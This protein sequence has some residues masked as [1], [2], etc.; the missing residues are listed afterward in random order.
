MANFCRKEHALI[1]DEIVS[2]DGAAELGPALCAPI[3]DIAGGL[4]IERLEALGLA[5]GG[6]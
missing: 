6:V 5:H 2:A 4:R 1:A 3:I